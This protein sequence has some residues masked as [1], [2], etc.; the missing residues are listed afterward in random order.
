MYFYF[1]CFFLDNLTSNLWLKGQIY[2][3]LTAQTSAALLIN[4]TIC[5]MLTSGQQG[6]ASAVCF[7]SLCLKVGPLREGVRQFLFERLKDFFQSDGWT[8]QHVFWNPSLVVTLPQLTSVSSVTNW[9]Q[10]VQTFEF[11]IKLV[12]P[13]L[14][15][16]ASSVAWLLVLR[17][18]SCPNK[19]KIF[20]LITYY[21]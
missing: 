7:I 4:D 1:Y 8:A 16:R 17:T 18:G 11:I 21:Y 19:T 6:K 10:C 12:S 20:C 14:L 3:D 9:E 13:V 15:T 2:Q 5:Q